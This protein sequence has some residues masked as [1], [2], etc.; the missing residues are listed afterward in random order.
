MHY[1]FNIHQNYVQPCGIPAL[2]HFFHFKSGFNMFQ[3][4][5]P[6]VGQGWI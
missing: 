6:D 2:D 5:L 1:A 4:D 3:D